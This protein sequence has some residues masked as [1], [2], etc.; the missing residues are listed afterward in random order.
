MASSSKRSLPRPT[1]QAPAPQPL[2][3]KLS[4][5]PVDKLDIDAVHHI[6]FDRSVRELGKVSGDSEAL[7]LPASAEECSILVNRWKH[8]PNTASPAFSLRRYSHPE[9]VDFKAVLDQDTNNAR[10][11]TFY[12]PQLTS[13]C[14]TFDTGSIASANPISPIACNAT[15]FIGMVARIVQDEYAEWIYDPRS[16]DGPGMSLKTR[17]RLLED[18]T[19]GFELQELAI[20]L[21]F[22]P[23][24]R[25]GQLL[26]AAVSTGSRVDQIVHPVTKIVLKPNPSFLVKNSS[27]ALPFSTTKTRMRPPSPDFDTPASTSSAPRLQRHKLSRPRPA[28]APVADVDAEEEED[29]DVVSNEF[30]GSSKLDVLITRPSIARV[31][32]TKPKIPERRMQKLAGKSRAT[33]PVSLLDET[34]APK[35]KERLRIQ[36]GEPDYRHGDD[37]DTSAH[38]RFVTNPHFKPKA[39]FSDLISKSVETSKRGA[40]VPFLRAP[41]WQLSEEMKDFGAFA[42]IGETTFSLQGLSRFGYASSRFLWPTNNRTLPSPEALYSTNNCLTCTTRGEVCESSE[43]PGGVCRQCNGTHRSCPSCLSLEDHRDRFLALHSHVQGYP[44]GYAAS[45]DQYASTLD[46]ITKLQASFVPL[47]QDAQQALLKSMQTVRSSGFDLNVV[48][49]RWAE[50]N[51]NL[52][53][54]YDIVTWLATLFGWDSSCNLVDYLSNPEDRERLEAFMRENLPAPA[55]PVAPAIPSLIS[56][57]PLPDLKTIESSPTSRRRPAA[58]TPINFVSD[59][60]FHT[61]LPESTT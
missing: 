39:P 52:P 54:D 19:E 16:R 17:D 41:K 45:L 2:R 31:A 58:A 1:P 36:E 15:N 55:D 6:H 34:S 53:L 38:S 14:T 10:P 40:K 56:P 46:H 18:I 61:P 50:D 59:G 30:K 26:L 29:G 3:K 33:P 42:T 49:S 5:R 60:E 43:K 12:P 44:V 22:D 57:A 21:P 24:T 20:P 48:L 23:S 32:K 9:E 37:I 28:A 8:L 11:D 27:L 25:E 35:G 51:P 47:F 4:V 7:F 13:F